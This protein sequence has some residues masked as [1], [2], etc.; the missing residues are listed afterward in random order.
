MKN[1]LITAFEAFGG[2]TLNPTELIL[3]ELPESMD[4]YAL[5]K[6]LLPVEYVRAR[7]LACA[8]CDALSPAAVILLGQ[9]GGRSAITPETRGRNLMYARIPDNAG[10]GPDHLPLTEGGPEY[11]Y[12]GLPVTKIVSQLQEEGIPAESSDDAGTY[13]CNAVLYGVL[14]HVRGEV[15][16]GFIHV[17]FIREQG[18]EDLPFLE[19]ETIRRGILTAVGTVIGE[20]KTPGQ[21]DGS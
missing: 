4:G 10:Y 12:A 6:L 11:L 18:H 3:N 1:I 20:L 16:A 8:A 21:D 13:V 2:D 9:A 17:P 14:L 19:F 7:E 5:K 15:P